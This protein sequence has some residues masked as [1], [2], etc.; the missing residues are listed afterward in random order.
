MAENLS[1][2]SSNYAESHD[3]LTVVRIDTAIDH[4]I[5]SGL[6]KRQPLP[7]RWLYDTHQI[8][9]GTD[10]NYWLHTIPGLSGHAPVDLSSTFVEVQKGKFLYASYHLNID[11]GPVLKEYTL[12]L[13]GGLP[14]SDFAIKFLQEGVTQTRRFLKVPSL[15]HLQA[16]LE[17]LWNARPLK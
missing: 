11:H 15:T 12:D 4:I 10:I 16:T 5:S 13:R 17:L 9:P 3:G 14:K 1:L 6:G 8:D 2:R 7:K